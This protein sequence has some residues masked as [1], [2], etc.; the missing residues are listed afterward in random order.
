MFYKI[1]YEA[2]HYMLRPVWSSSGVNYW[3]R[4]LL[5]S[6]SLLQLLIFI[7]PLDAHVR[8]KWWVVFPPVV[9][10]AASSS[11][12]LQ[13]NK[14]LYSGNLLGR[15][16]YE[17]HFKKRLFEHKSGKKNGTV[18]VY[19]SAFTFYQWGLQS[20]QNKLKK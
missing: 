13:S 8:S 20:Y 6:V 1:Y 7:S 17:L 9:C 11:Y 12:R 5:S 15:R 19:S 3:T 18:Y 2:L 10:C 14:I 16:L 4:K